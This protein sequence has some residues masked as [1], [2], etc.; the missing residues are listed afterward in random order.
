MF[1][2]GSQAIA[3]QGAG[4]VNGFA[5]NCRHWF[6]VASEWALPA[7]VRILFLSILFWAATYSDKGI[8]YVSF[9]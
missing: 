9:W 8:I 4:E 6:P 5:S 2:S 1:H 7:Q 3:R